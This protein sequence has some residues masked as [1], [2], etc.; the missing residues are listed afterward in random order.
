[1]P[2]PSSRCWPDD[3]AVGSVVFGGGLAGA[4]PRGGAHISMST[5]GVAF[6]KMLATEHAAR[7]Q[8]YLAAPVFGR[9]DAAEAGKLWVVAAGEAAQVERFRPLFEAMGRGVSVVGDGAVEGQCRKALRQ[10]HDRR[11]HRSDG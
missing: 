10:L 4:I 3:D 5:I 8:V 11:R 7:G 6:S 2:R 1:M 9:P